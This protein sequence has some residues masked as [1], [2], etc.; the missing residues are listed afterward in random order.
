MSTTGS[1]HSAPAGL[2]VVGGGPA[3]H[4]AA[5]AYREAGGDDRV[6]IISA[7]TAPP[8]ERPPLSKDYLRGES[9]EDSLRLESAQFYRDHEIEMRLADPVVG[10]ELDNATVDTLSGERIGYRNCVLATGCDPAQLPVRGADHPQ[11]LRL[12][13]VTSARLLRSAAVHAQSALVIGSGFIGCEAAVSLAMRGLAVT[14][15]ST[16]ELPQI[17]RLGRAAAERIAGWL[18]WSGVHLQPNA[19][20]AEIRDGRTVVAHDGSTFEA[21]MILSAAG[22]S[23]NSSPAEKAGLQVDQGRIVVDARMA[24]SVP[25][26]YAAGDVAIAHN[27]AAGRPLR[28]EHWGEALRMGEIAGVNAAGGKDS[29]SDVPGFWSQIGHHQLKYTAWGDGFDRDVLV[30]HDGD[31]FT[32]WYSRD[33]KAVGVLTHKSDADYELGRELISKGA[34]LPL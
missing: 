2:V 25:G 16:D 8:Y 6:V 3:G 19:E 31:A 15:V 33:G 17:G 4:S 26:V 23:P 20:V 9:D 29:W 30:E 28:V 14:V 5:A 12:R 24:T 18:S 11:I 34:P 13:S 10:L 7:D 1:E 27:D 22:V 21:D 32:V